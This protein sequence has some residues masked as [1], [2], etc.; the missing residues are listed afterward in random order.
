M[1][2]RL[3]HP[4]VLFVLAWPWAPAGSPVSAQ[5]PSLIHELEVFAVAG[6]SEHV[7]LPS[8]RGF[9]A[10]LQWEFGGDWLARLSYQRTTD[11]TRKWGNVCSVYSPRIG[12]RT[13]M[14]ESSVA[15]GGLRG[16]ILRGVRLGDR[17][18]GAVG[19]GLSFSQVKARSRGEQGGRAD[20]LAP[21]A[22]QIGYLGILS[23]LV[24]PLRK[25]PVGVMGT[26]TSH[27]VRFNSCSGENPPQYDPFC[28]T[29][30]FREVELGLA[31][32]F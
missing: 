27:W 23:V 29:S 12:C 17:V 13:E 8:P 21:N 31:Y 32:S 16:G 11:A 25:V 30:S 14:T 9:G 6:S 28:G 4:L 15:L 7:E 10:A 18:R 5:Q 26:F 19:G 2:Y 20:L 3:K 1:R 24:T 22:G